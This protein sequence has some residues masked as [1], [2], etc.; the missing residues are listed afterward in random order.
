MPGSCGWLGCDRSRWHLGATTRST[1]RCHLRRTRAR[2]PLSSRPSPIRDSLAVAL[3]L[4]KLLRLYRRLGEAS[5]GIF[6]SATAANHDSRYPL[7]TAIVLAL[8][9]AAMNI[10]LWRSE[11]HTSE[12][13]SLMRLSYA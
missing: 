1:F 11:E 10:G 8:I 5:L 9:V 13:Q 3:K 2:L 4:A 6:L 12:L 7:L